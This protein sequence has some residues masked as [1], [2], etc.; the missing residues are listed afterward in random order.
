MTMKPGP[1]DPKWLRLREARVIAHA[2]IVATNLPG[3]KGRTRISGHALKAGL[4]SIWALPGERLSYQTLGRK[5][6]CSDHQA[7][8]IIKGLLADRLI[9][10]SRTGRN[11]GTVYEIH[12]ER[13]LELVP[14]D[15][16]RQMLADSPFTK[17]RPGQSQIQH[18]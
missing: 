6:G 15:V 12:V 14:S 13:L 18:G 9:S 4:W 11:V 17:R 10:R 5:T 16:V 7:K 3:S 2:E 8:R 1:V